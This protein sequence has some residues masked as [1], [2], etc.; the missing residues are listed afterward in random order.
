LWTLLALTTP[1]ITSDSA[2]CSDLGRRSSA[3][4]YGAA[5]GRLAPLVV[6]LH[7]IRYQMYF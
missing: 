4:G 6:A 2:K 3:E 1:M 5:A 7:L